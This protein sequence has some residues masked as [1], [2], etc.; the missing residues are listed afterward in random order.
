M[1]FTT[2]RNG[3]LLLDIPEKCIV[4]EFFPQIDIV[5]H[6]DTFDISGQILETAE[7]KDGALDNL[8]VGS[9]QQEF[10]PDVHLVHYAKIAGTY[11]GM[12]LVSYI[13]RDKSTVG[14]Y[15]LRRVIELEQSADVSAE[16]IVVGNG[17]YEVIA[18]VIQKILNSFRF[19]FDEWRTAQAALSVTKE[20]DGQASHSQSDLPELPD[21]P[22]EIRYLA[23]SVQIV[24]ADNS[25]EALED[26]DSST[27]DKAMDSRIKGLS[28]EEAKRLLEADEKALC[29]WIDK[30]PSEWEYLGFLCDILLSRSDEGLRS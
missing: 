19:Y 25:R 28:G 21:F 18:S 10:D 26:F 14:C 5:D 9:A 27:L 4:N 30:G 16:F 20:T 7:E 17:H 22:E 3:G 29:S 11:S 23:E 8:Q 2:Y 24:L 15:E 6:A 12:E 13:C 1:Q